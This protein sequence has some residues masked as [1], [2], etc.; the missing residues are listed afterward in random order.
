LDA[1]EFVLARARVIATNE[2]RFEL[3]WQLLQQLFVLI[4]LQESLTDIVLFELGD[5]G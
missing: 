4:L 3:R 5:D 2:Q 1:P